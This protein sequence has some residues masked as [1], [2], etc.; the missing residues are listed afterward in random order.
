LKISKVSD[1]YCDTSYDIIDN[2]TAKGTIEKTFG[3]YP[4]E[5][6]LKVYKKTN[7]AY[8]GDITVFAVNGDTRLYILF[9]KEKTWIP[10]SMSD[11][12]WW[13]CTKLFWYSGK[14]ANKRFEDDYFW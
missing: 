10:K 2:I 1:V 3:W 4:I 6:S 13:I 12:P 11:N 9:E 14:V 5:T 8:F 7:K